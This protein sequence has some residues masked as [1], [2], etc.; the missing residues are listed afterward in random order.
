MDYIKEIVYSIIENEKPTAE[1]NLQLRKVCDVENEV[2]DQLTKEQQDLYRKI[3]LE[4]LELESINGDHL[5]ELTYKVCK[6][7]FCKN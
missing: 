6:E 5:I 3:E 1:H 4:I 7:L 2:F